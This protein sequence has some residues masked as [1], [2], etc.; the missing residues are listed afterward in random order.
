MIHSGLDA[1]PHVQEKDIR[2]AM[3]VFQK[4]DSLFMFHAEV[5]CGSHFHNTE[6]IHSSFLIFHFF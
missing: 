5:D 2:Q 4:H 3:E 1:F 6:V